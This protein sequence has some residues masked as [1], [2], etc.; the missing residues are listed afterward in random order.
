MKSEPSTL[1]LSFVRSVCL[2]YAFHELG[3]VLAGRQLQWRNLPGLKSERSAFDQRFAEALEGKAANVSFLRTVKSFIRKGFPLW[4]FAENNGDSLV[5]E[6]LVAPRLDLWLIFERHPLCGLGNAFS[7]GLGV[8]LG[9]D[10]ASPS[11]SQTLNLFKLFGDGNRP[12]WTFATGEELKSSLEVAGGLL[13][14]VLPAFEELATPLLYPLPNH[15]PKN[16]ESRGALTARR[17]LELARPIA[18]RWR[19]DACLAVVKGDGSSSPLDELDP[20]TVNGKLTPHGSWSYLFLCPQNPAGM[21]IS[22]PSI[23]LIKSWEFVPPESFSLRPLPDAW[24][25]TDR[26]FKLAEAAGGKA[27]HT[28]PECRWTVAYELACDPERYHFAQPIWRLHYLAQ[29]PDPPA[30]QMITLDAAEGKLLQ[31]E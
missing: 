24:M 11:V 7:L 28:A 31:R 21:W 25:D 1:P 26:A 10:D 3:R 19:A 2:S 23:G 14:E 5:F 18:A 12:G 6:N 8:R 30:A 29:S 4:E 13:Q 27:L 17:G 9:S 15:L 20:P 22:V 16:A